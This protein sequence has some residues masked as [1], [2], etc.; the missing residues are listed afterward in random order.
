MIHALYPGT[1]DPVTNGHVDIA[2]RASGLFDKL[3]IAVFDSPSTKTILFPTKERVD[4]MKKAV[5]HIDHI[6]VIS[7]S[8]LTFELA[9]KIDSQVLIRGL[10]MGSD[11]DYEFEMSLMNR[12]VAPDLDTVCLMTS[13]EYEFV[14]SSLIKEMAKLGGA[15]KEFVP[16]HVAIALKE[17]YDQLG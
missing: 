10:R 8:C 7:Y 5:E 2:K 14:S 17:K 16:E 3:T 13:Q 15:L 6:D 4:M 12:K 1:F 9:K 11:F